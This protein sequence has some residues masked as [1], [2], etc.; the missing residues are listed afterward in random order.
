[1]SSCPHSRI[2]SEPVSSPAPFS[3]AVP[4]GAGSRGGT[5]AVTP[6]TSTLTWPTVTPTSAIELRGPGSSVPMTMPSSRGR[7][8]LASL[9]IPFT[10]SD[11]CLRHE[12]AAEVWVG[13]RT[14][15]TEVPARASRIREALLAAGAR[16]IAAV[17]HP[18]EALL[19]VH[20]AALVEFLRTAWDEWAAADLPSDRVVPYVFARE[21]L[22]PAPVVPTAVWAR[23]GLFAYDTM[24]L[25]GPG[26][27][28]AARAAVDVALTAVDLVAEG[29]R[30]VY[31]CCRPPGH[32]VTR[33]LYGGSCYLNN[34]AVAAAELRRRL[35][36]PVA[37]VDIDAHHGNGTQE[38]FRDRDDVRTASVHV[39]PGAGWFPHFLG[40]AVRRATTRTSTCRSLP[41]PATSRGSRPCERQRSSPRARAALVVALGVDAAAADPESPLQV[42]A[43]GYREAGRILGALGLPTVV[44]QEGGYDLGTIGELVVATLDGASRCRNTRCG[45][46]PMAGRSAS[47]PA[48]A[49]TTCGRS[50]TG[51]SSGGSHRGTASS[52][53]RACT[54]ATTT[55]R[56]TRAAAPTISTRS[57]PIQRST[58]SSRCRAGSG[59]A[60][61]SP[62]STSTLLA[63]NPKA[64][65]GYSDITSLHVPIRQRAGFP[66]FYGYGL[67]GIG[68]KETTAFAA[69]ACCRCCAATWSARCRA[70]PTTRMCARSRRGRAS[71]PARRRLPLA[72]DA[73]A[74][75]ALGARDATGRSSSSRTPTRRRTSSTAS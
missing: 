29:E 52:S 26:T 8:T 74:R 39:D 51:A 59:R 5:T 71:G 21:G 32:H 35:D 62:I 65:I 44:V 9:V 14:P 61:C 25:I 2:S 50:S 36:G 20:D 69:T 27:W 22:T 16:E 30:A 43:D 37:V 33:S 3:T 68:D 38:L 60:R 53:A 49:P 42:T 46:F 11:D 72:S 15:A 24:T 55:S 6:V 12:P 57:S 34:A 58:S 1:M 70:T 48:R 13:V 23:P 67:V 45:R 54:T 41:A 18:D 64:F 7:D 17:A 40:F 28:E 4:A 73:D 63:A 66:T 75:N 19:A 56:A 47:P 10:W 31:A